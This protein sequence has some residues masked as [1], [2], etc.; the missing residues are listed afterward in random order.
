MYELMEDRG[1]HFITM[2]YVSGQDLK[3]LIRQTGQLTIGKAITIAKQVCEGLSEAHR[4]G[5]IHRDLKPNNI[6]IDKDGNARIMDFGVARSLKSKSITGA[7]VMI[8]TPEY[9]SPEQ[10]DGKDVD[11]RS[12][13]YSLGIILYEMLAGRL[14]FEGDTPFTI[15]VKQKSQEPEDPKKF[16]PRIPD[17]LNRLILNCLEKDRENRLQSTGEVCSVLIQIEQ[18]VLPTERESTPKKPLTSKEITV[19]FGLKK[20][21]VPALVLFILLIVLVLVIW[22]PFSQKETA[23][24]PEKRSSIAVISFENHTGDP[25]F[26]HLKKVIPN[27]LITSLEQSQYFSVMTWERMSDLLKQIGKEDID[28]VDRNLGFELCRVVFRSGGDRSYLCGSLFRTGL[29]L[30]CRGGNNCP[31]RGLGKR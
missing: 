5:V 27:L 12:D 1:S 31:E 25:A 9:M 14:P 6:M 22:K 18:S 29:D 24:L 7:G 20:T 15:G 17:D 19:T 11:Q 8:G 4:L 13:I 3:K 10:V 2:E 26:D 21:L 28:L 23:L 30:W 16:N